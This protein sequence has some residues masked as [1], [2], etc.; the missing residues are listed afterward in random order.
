MSAKSVPARRRVDL[1]AL[2]GGVGTLLVAAYLLGD[3][4]GWS[5]PDFDLRWLL[6]GAAG[7]AGVA[8]LASSMR[9]R[10]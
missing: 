2:I 3:G 1:L 5:L 7:L 6:A 9:R 4:A 10:N 8:L